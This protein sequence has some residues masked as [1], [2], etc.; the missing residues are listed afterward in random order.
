MLKPNEIVEI[1]DN[2]LVWLAT[3]N[4]NEEPSVSPKEVYFAVDSCIYIAN[5]ASP[6]S[7]NNIASN[8]N[9]ALST[10]HPLVQK[11]YKIKGNALLLTREDLEFERGQKLL[12][13]ITK[14]LYPFD[15]IIK[16]TPIKVEKIVAPSYF[17][18]PD[19]SVD[20]KVQLAKKNYGL[21]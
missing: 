8:S 1:N 2:I 19:Q 12:E 17:L 5:I 3:V 7:A 10:I 6:N 18:F 13:E 20:E 16:V 21:L 15:G 11:R 4:Q 9:V 14:G